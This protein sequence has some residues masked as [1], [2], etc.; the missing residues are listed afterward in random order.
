M[1]DYETW[2]D[3]CTHIW[4]DNPFHNHFIHV[5][6]EKTDAE[7]KELAKFHVPNFYEAWQEKKTM[8]SGQ[9]LMT[10]GKLHVTIEA[11]EAKIAE[12]EAEKAKTKPAKETK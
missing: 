4:R 1:S 8:R 2:L 7:I 5:D 3:T 11:M 6:S 9:L 10:I 12:L